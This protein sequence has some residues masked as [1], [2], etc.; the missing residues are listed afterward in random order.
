MKT[1]KDVLI[2]TLLLSIV[3]GMPLSLHAGPFRTRF[4]CVPPIAPN[5]DPLEFRIRDQGQCAENELYMELRSGGDG[6]TLLLPAE[7]ALT[8]EEQRDIEKYRKYFGGK[9]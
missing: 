3:L 6:S 8:P 4:V 9:R 5:E 1:A 7:E 2:A